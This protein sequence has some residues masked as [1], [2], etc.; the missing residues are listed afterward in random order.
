MDLII[1]LLRLRLL[2]NEIHYVL[3]FLLAPRLETRRIMEDK[4]WIALEGE[5]TTH[6]VDPPLR[7]Q[8]QSKGLIML[9]KSPGRHLRGRFEL[10]VTKW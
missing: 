7:C 4:S 5:C 9:Q 6:I 3:E 1:N 8:N 10:L 2:L